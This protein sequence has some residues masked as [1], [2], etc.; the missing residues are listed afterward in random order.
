MLETCESAKSDKAILIEYPSSEVTDFL[1]L[2]HSGTIH[3]GWTWPRCK[4]LLS[5]IDMYD[6]PKLQPLVLFRLFDIVSKAPWEIFALASHADCVALAKLAIARLP[7]DLEKNKLQV[8]TID[9][10]S[11]SSVRLDYLLGFLGA[12]NGRL[13]P[14]EPA[15]WE[16]IAAAFTPRLRP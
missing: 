7:A 6:A 5:M 3:G 15:P 2:M 4:T 10:R 12:S 13:N 8:T 1:D 11:A 9:T 14:Y 16:S